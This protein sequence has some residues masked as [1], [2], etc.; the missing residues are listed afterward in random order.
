M[1]TVRTTQ[2]GNVYICKKKQTQ[3]MQ[4]VFY[5]SLSFETSLLAHK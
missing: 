4:S 3:Q 5:D 1:D 2:E